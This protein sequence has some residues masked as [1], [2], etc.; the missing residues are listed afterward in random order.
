LP[1]L[2]NFLYRRITT[3][4]QGIRSENRG[5]GLKINT[6]LHDKSIDVP[7]LSLTT[8]F[9]FESLQLAPIE[10]PESQLIVP[11]DVTEYDRFSGASA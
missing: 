2:I 8:G 4:C 5:Y 6:I 3:G 9:G 1:G 7:F 11:I 10:V